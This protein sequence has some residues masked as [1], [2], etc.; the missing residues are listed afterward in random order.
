MSMS[1]DSKALRDAAYE[2]GLS[3]YQIAARAGLPQPT[4]SDVLLGR[5]RPSTFALERICDVLEIDPDE[6]RQGEA[7]AL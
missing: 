5:R 4:V 6:A 3:T 7:N 2:L 1:V